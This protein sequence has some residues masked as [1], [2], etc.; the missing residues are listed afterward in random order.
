MIHACTIVARDRLARA[1]V[2]VDSFRRH[3][4]DGSFVVLLVDEPGAERPTVAGAEVLLLDEI[5]VPAPELERLRIGYDVAELVAAVR[6]WLL[7]AVLDR[8][9]P[10]V[11]YVDADVSIERRITELP[12]LVRDHSVVLTPRLTEPPPPGEPTALP[13]GT[14]DPGFVAVGDTVDGRRLLDWWAAHLMAQPRVVAG[15]PPTDQRLLDLVPGLFQHVVVTDPSWNVASWNLPT[16]SLD[17]GDDGVVRVDGR[18][19]TFVQLTG[20]AP[21]EPHLLSRDQGPDPR[22]LLS[23]DP[24]LRELCDDY[25]RRLRGASASGDE[26][27]PIIQAYDGVPLT[28]LVRDVVRAEPAR[29][30]GQPLVEWLASEGPGDLG[31]LGRLL[32]A[33]YV[34]RPDLQQAFPLVARG[35]VRELLDWAEHFGRREHDIPDVLLERVR[36]RLAGSP[37]PAGLLSRPADRARTTRPVHGVELAGYLTANLGVGEAARQF[38]RSLEGAGVALSTTTYAATGSVRGTPWR[39]R[40]PEEGTRHDTLLMCV[41]A[42]E[43]T[44]FQ[45]EAGPRYLRARHR[46]GLWFWELDVLPDEMVPALDLVDEVW[47]CSEFYAEAIRSRTAKPVVVL[48]LPVRAPVRQELSIRE[49][50]DDGTFTFL[51][52]FDHFSRFQRKNPLG[53]VAAFR[54]AFP[55]PGEARLVIK[56][57]NGAALPLDRERLRYAVADR[58]DVVLIERDVDRA[59]LDALMWACD[60]YVSLHRSE[61]FGQTVGEMMAIGKPVVATAYSGSMELTR[62]DT[63]FLVDVDLAAVPP[64]CE[65]YPAGATWAEPRTDHAAALMRQVFDDPDEARARGKRAADDIAHRFSQESLGAA[66]RTRLEAIWR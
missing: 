52:V 16:R 61:G 5:G 11:A 53:A 51:F 27:P 31:R 13:A 40:L 21:D 44:A 47:T 1:R 2:L 37:R 33:V 56:S 58:P 54:K 48:P 10:H 39:D 14:F 59:E 41:N 63:S 25:G 42:D 60:G 6:P 28:P 18:P 65:P 29:P 12:G 45:H 30:A 66:A 8:G 19:L 64:G 38:A 32:T 24:V 26:R 23:E 20:Y 35:D 22:V 15:G 62:P 4:D 49:L 36:D 43:I 50:P 7:R 17:R 9:H 46:I 55:R 34:A 3:H 57:I